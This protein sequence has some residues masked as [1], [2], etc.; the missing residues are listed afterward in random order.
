[1]RTDHTLERDTMK[2]GT[3]FRFASL[4]LCSVLGTGVATTAAAQSSSGAE[5]LLN[6]KWVINLGGFVVGSSVNA[7]LNGQS[8]SNP[9][10][11]FDDSFGKANDATRIRGDLLWRITPEHRMRFMYFNN[12][13]TRSRVL[14][15]DVQWGDYTF[16]SGS[17]AEFKNDFQVFEL[18]YE[19]AF[20]RRPTYEVAASLGVHY[21]D[22][23]LQLS[24]TA[25]GI[26]ANGN[27][28]QGQATSKVSSLPAP[29]PVIGLRAGWVVAP[30]W[31]VDAQAQVFRVKVGA[32]DGNWSDLRLGATWMFHRNYGLGLGYNRFA[33]KVDVDKNDFNG[34]L[35]LDYSGLQ[36]YLTGSF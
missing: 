12:S 36:A 34:S 1:L 23:K 24:G 13:Q 28:F 25:S 14:E 18:A 2:T 15:N 5:G 19:Y 6:D 8:S 10:V 16:N 33:T 22:L 7:N 21:M 35:K 27:P 20:V 29:L 11:D 31:Y 3:P 26:D 9:E 30:D 4:L 17:R 32:Y